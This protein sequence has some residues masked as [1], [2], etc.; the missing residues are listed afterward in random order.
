MR[1]RIGVKQLRVGMYLDE[2]CCSWLEHP[3]WRSGFVITDAHDIELIQASKIAEVWI[4]ISKGVDTASGVASTSDAEA[5]AQ[6]D[7]ELQQVVLDRPDTTAAE[8]SASDEDYALAANLCAHAKQVVIELFQQVRMG[9]AVDTAGAECLVEEVLESVSRNTG[10]LIS[11]V[12][13]KEVSE[14]T[15]MHSV[16]VCA[17]MVALGL[18]LGLDRK[19]VCTAGLAGLMHDLGK[20]TLPIDVLHKPGKLSDDEFSIVKRHPEEGLKLLQNCRVDPAVLDVCANHHARM[21]GTG[22]PHGLK[23]DGISQFAKMAAVCDVYDAI[24]SGRPYKSAWDPA[25]SMRKMAE[26][27]NGHFDPVVFH[28]F[29]KSVG[30]YPVGS[31]VRLSSGKLGVVVGQSRESLLTPRVKVFFS[32][33][34]NARIAHDVVDLSNPK[35]KE[36]I[37]AREDPAK[38]NFADLN[39]LWSGQIGL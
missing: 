8:G 17:L 18:R 21:D 35:V 29:V 26:W 25:E 4:D 11:L 27:A 14:F 1:K 5:D 31:L 13:L 37:E 33:K 2:F 16:A 9:K 22:Y 19:N 20:A 12:R 39:E 23:G 38:W 24:S 7:A 30:I 34:L 6:I 28:A 3:F 15:Y 32:T 10:A 36:K